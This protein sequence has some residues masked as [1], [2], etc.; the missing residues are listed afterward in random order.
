MARN[1]HPEETVK[2]ILEAAALLFTKKGYDNTSLQDIINETHLSKGAI[3]HHF[4]SKEDIFSRI[5]EDISI[6]NGAALGK[7][8]DDINL[9][10]A[11][12]LR[13]IFR[14]A[15]MHQNQRRML[16]MVPYLLD[17]PKFLAVQIK[18]IYQQSVPYYMKPIL[19]EGIKDGSIKAHNPKELAE[20]IMTLS[21]IWLHPLLRATDTYSMK[22][23]CAVFNS[24]FRPVVG[25]DI[26]NEEIMDAYVDYSQLLSQRGGD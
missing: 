26:L 25:F 4:T 1:K 21:D 14:A 5:C 3:Y 20:A 11:E 6:E 24:L 17:N 2:R 15:V 18:S 8:R 7:I 9:N 16:G 13:E 19:E 12:K 22:S 10:G 23:R